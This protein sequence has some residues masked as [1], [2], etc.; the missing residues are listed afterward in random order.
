MEAYQ[1]KVAEL[2]ALNWWRYGSAK[3][4]LGTKM[5]GMGE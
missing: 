4:I 2:E 5:L 3:T 1:K